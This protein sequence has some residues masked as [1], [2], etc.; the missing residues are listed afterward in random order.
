V[1]GL[2]A[3]TLPFPPIGREKRAKREPVLRWEEPRN[4]SFQS[5]ERTISD[6]HCLSHLD[7]RID[8]HDLFVIAR[9]SQSG[10]CSGIYRRQIIAE[11]HDALDSWRMANST[12]LKRINELREQVS[13]KHRFNKP[14]GA[15]ARHLAKTQTRRVTW[16]IQLATQP[17]RS[18]VF[19]LR[20]RFQ[21]KPKRCFNK[22]QLRTGISHDANSR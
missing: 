20:L 7:F 2:G 4:Q 8:C 12:V 16:D 17:E 19:S 3:S 21:T 5:L 9:L 13:R 15:S 18:E 22:R 6:S 1:K 11:L 10:D 14:D